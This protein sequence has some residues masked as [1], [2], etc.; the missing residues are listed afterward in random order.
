[1]LAPRAA[2]ISLEFPL[3]TNRS[4]SLHCIP[5]AKAPFLQVTFCGQSPPTIFLFVLIKPTSPQSLG[6]TKD[7]LLEH[8]HPSDVQLSKLLV[9]SFRSTCSISR[10]LVEADTKTSSTLHIPWLQSRTLVVRELPV[11][12]YTIVLILLSHCTYSTHGV[13]VEHCCMVE[14]GLSIDIAAVAFKACLQR[15]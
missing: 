10:T 15:S 12:V 3:R 14:R 13:C 9:P 11:A 7:H 5:G 4:S 6:N 2:H 1:M 8:I